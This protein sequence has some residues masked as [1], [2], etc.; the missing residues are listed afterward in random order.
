MT[1]HDWR[2]RIGDMLEAIAE[3]GRYSAGYTFDTF[4][5]DEKAVDAVVRN[6]EIIGEAAR[7]V[8]S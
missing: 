6:V 5:A 7:H 8:P 3:I 2:V 4:I 1:A